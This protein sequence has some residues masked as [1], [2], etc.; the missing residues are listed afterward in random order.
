[1][2][3]GFGWLETIMGPGPT[4]AQGMALNIDISLQLP[5]DPS[6]SKGLAILNKHTLMRIAQIFI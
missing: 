1:M 2:G 6:G 4:S 3:N 5:I